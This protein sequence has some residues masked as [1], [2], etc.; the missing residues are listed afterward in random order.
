MA[1][2]LT[3]SERQQHDHYRHDLDKRVQRLED[4]SAAV[5]EFDEASEPEGDEEALEFRGKADDA[6]TELRKAIADYNE[7]V[8]EVNSFVSDKAAEMRGEYDDKAETWQESE[9]G[10]AANDMI[11]AWE[12]FEIGTA[13]EDDGS[14]EDMQSEFSDLPLEPSE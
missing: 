4:A 9:K 7:L 12:S 8:F 3:K 10:S 14:F 13:D 6:A 5:E 11:E 1:F 2:K